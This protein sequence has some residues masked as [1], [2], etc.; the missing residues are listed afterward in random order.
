MDGEKVVVG[1]W[2]QRLTM[3]NDVDDPFEIGDPGDVALQTWFGDGNV[4]FEDFSKLFGSYLQEVTVFLD[5][6]GQSLLIVR[7]VLLEVG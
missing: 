4:L 2:A 6:V 5:P 3:T 1:W 7:K